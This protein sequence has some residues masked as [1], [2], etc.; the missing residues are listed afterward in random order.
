MNKY[1]L[2]SIILLN[3]NGLK[4]LKRT[5]PPLMRLKYPNY[6][7]NV[8][9]NGS[10]DGSLEY[11]KT[12]DRIKL[13]ISPKLKEKN[14]AC[15]YAVQRVKGNFILLL[16]N[17]L[18]ITDESILGQLFAFYKQHLD[19]GFITIAFCDEY[20]KVTSSYGGY[21]CRYFIRENKSI[22]NKKR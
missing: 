12:N 19:V 21:F 6:D 14:F 17:D 22:D 7:V 4:Y 18:L 3:Y 13:L 8:V 5:I 10:T 9:D 16:D 1:P 15:N 20:S 11:L 2:I